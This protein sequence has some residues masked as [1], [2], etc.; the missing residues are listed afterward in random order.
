MA[1]FAIGWLV[2]VRAAGVAKIDAVGVGPEGGVD[3]LD[4]FFGNRFWIVAVVFVI[5]FL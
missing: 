5:T 3:N 4:I 2:R 1:V